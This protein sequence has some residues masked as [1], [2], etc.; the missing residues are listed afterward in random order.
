MLHIRHFNL[1]IKSLFMSLVSKG[2]TI[3]NPQPRTTEIGDVSHGGAP[4]IMSSIILCHLAQLA[5]YTSEDS[6]LHHHGRVMARKER[7]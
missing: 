2:T 7:Q 4:P 5:R 3:H 1:Y 6:G